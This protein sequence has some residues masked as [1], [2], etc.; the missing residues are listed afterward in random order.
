MNGYRELWSKELRVYDIVAAC[1]IDKGKAEQRA[2]SS[3][4]VSRW[5]ET[6]SLYRH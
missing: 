4:R 3:A 5:H 1:D 6:R 2:N